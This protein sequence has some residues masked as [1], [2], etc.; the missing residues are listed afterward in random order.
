MRE[1]SIKLD[2]SIGPN[3]VTRLRADRNNFSLLRNKAD[4]CYK[5]MGKIY[6]VNT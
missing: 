5:R 4:S 2:I 6:L 3:R 1:A